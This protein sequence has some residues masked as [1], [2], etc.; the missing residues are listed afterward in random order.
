MA[1]LH[2]ITAQTRSLSLPSVVC[3]GCGD[4][5]W[6]KPGTWLSTP[7]IS[8]VSSLLTYFPSAFNPTVELKF[9]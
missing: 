9:Y 1:A 7:W 6:L 4:E 3:C 5:G 2:A 8:K